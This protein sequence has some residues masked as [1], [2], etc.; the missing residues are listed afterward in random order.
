[1]NY[2]HRS[3]QTIANAIAKLARVYENVFFPLKPN[4]YYDLLVEMPN[5]NNK[6]LVMRVKVIY[7]DCRAPS[8]TYVVNLRKSGGYVNK[9]EVKE[10]FQNDMCDI[11]FVECP[12]GFYEIP[13]NRITTH[14]AISLSMYQEFKLPVSS[15][16]EQLAVN[17]L[18]VGSIPSQAD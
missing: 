9:K 10:D 14:R 5:K 6:Y 3:Y 12:E 4:Y 16:V 2:H 17:Q 13:T 11:L 1:M 7:T 18:V 8:G 15:A